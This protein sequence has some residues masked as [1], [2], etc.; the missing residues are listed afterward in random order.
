MRISRSRYKPSVIA[1]GETAILR[2]SIKGATKVLIAEVSASS[3]DLQKIGTFAGSGQIEVRPREDT[4]YVLT[5]EGSTTLKCASAS[6]R[7]RVK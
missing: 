1:P 3:R 5:C 6:V 4:I 7:V 2:W